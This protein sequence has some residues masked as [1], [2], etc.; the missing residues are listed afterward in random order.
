MGEE[1]FIVTIVFLGIF[2]TIVCPI[3]IA[4]WLIVRLSGGKKSGQTSNAEES[5]LMQEIFHGL[6]KMEQRVETLETL[7]M[8]RETP[9]D[10]S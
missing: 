1:V 5:Q 9:G 2:G 6:S 7:L 8:E 3:A 10:K 4:A